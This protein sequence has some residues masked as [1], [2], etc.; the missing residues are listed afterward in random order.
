MAPAVDWARLEVG[1]REISRETICLAAIALLGLGASLSDGFYSDGGLL[2]VGLGIVLVLLIRSG[3]PSHASDL[4]WSATVLTG[5]MA[6]GFLYGGSPL[7]WVASTAAGGA[8]AVVVLC[9][10][11]ALRMAAAAVSAAIWV[12]L[13]GLN[14]DWG[15]TPIDVVLVIR[16]ATSKL[17]VGV[18]PYAASY[19]SSTPGLASSHYPYGPGVL[20]LSVPGRLLGDVRLSD[21]LAALV[22]IT[23]VV[24]L[25]RR[26]GGSEQGWRCLALCLTLPFLPHMISL[27]F[28]ELYL[29]AAIAVWLC[30]TDTHT[31]AATAVL[32]VG[33]ST[34]PMA[35][36]LLAI[37]FVWWPQP[38][39]QILV[40]GAF[41]VAIC[42]PFV[43]WAGL[44]HFITDTVGLQLR[45]GPRATGL[46]LDAFWFRL[47]HGWP[48][49]WV[50]PVVTLAALTLL[51]RVRERTWSTA[52]FLGAGWLGVSL[53][54]AKWAFFNYY[55]VVAAGA[56]LGLS[57][58]TW[59]PPHPLLV[60]RG[61]ALGQGHMTES[62]DLRDP[63]EAPALS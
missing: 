40:A 24:V 47:T 59:P 7:L 12:L 18:N 31:W 60:G 54:F 57:L 45:Q 3:K 16:G 23:A 25:A 28:P 56:L 49:I 46:D 52:L 43:L 39:R 17:L 53:L 62:A 34:L 8:A 15:R 2:L 20:L 51:V 55:F 32:G 14:V 11:R 4:V 48:S 38:R 27:G 63:T 10:W 1:L 50:W 44:E 35:I 22:L 19:A 33:L 41:A 58:L 42:C 36:A 9:A 6:T 30:W 29:A 13:L 61:G 21:L 5:A 37:A 26:H